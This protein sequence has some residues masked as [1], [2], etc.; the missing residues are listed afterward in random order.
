M[1]T[2]IEIQAWQQAR[3]DTLVK[4]E[5]LECPRCD[6]V[7]VA[8]GVDP[9]GTTAYRCSGPGHRPLGWRIDP[10]GNLMHGLKGQRFY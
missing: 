6:A 8:I 1:G 5:P 10:D 4:A 9:D 3:R 7:T 2:V